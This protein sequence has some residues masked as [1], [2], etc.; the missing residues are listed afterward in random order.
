VFQQSFRRFGQRPEQ[1]R[2][3]AEEQAGRG[4]GLEELSDCNSI[5]FQTQRTGIRIS[6]TKIWQP[7]SYYFN[8][9]LKDPIL[10]VF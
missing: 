5:T 7:N 3:R 10:G 4:G 1:K 9:N 6:S 8:V 2:V